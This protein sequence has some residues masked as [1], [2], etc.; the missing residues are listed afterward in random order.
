MTRQTTGANRA[1][2]WVLV[3]ASAGSCMAALDTLVVSTALTT[4]RS[5]LGATI[6]QLEWTTNAYNLSFAV[7]LLTAAALGDRFGRRRMFAS[8][9]GIFAVASAGCALAPT[10]AWLIAARAVQGIGAALIMTLA[11]ALISAAFAPERRGSALG[12]FFALTGLA[13]A[14]GPLLGGA[15]TEGIAWQWIF[16]LNVPIGIALVPLALA[17]VPESHGPDSALDLLGLVLV[18]GG[19]LG[20]V[21]GLVRGNLAGWDSAEVLATLVGGSLLVAA[22]VA[23]QR[24]A[25]QPMLPLGMFRSRAFSAANTAIFFAVGALFVGVFFLSQ[26]MQIALGS[27][28]LDAGVQLLPWTATLF[29]VAPVAGNLVDRFGERPF[30]VAGPTLQAIGMGWIAL[31]AD[32]DMAYGEM[33]APLIIAGIGVSMTFPAAQNSVVG[34]VPAAAIGKAAGVNST[35]RELGGVFGIALSVAVFAGAGSYA[36]PASFADGFV[37]AVGVAAGLSL[38]GALAGTAL[39]NRRAAEAGPPV[40][41]TPGL[42]LR[43]EQS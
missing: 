32:T 40:V 8:G 27:G 17:R 34:S 4:I 12:I 21:W 1:A 36:S 24:R 9:I 15:I 16:W 28:P 38:L 30:L 11:L 35:M 29:F 18:T 20:L 23:W 14:T 2:I 13:V 22:F 25:P 43:G 37:S 26:F 42:E 10:V 39:P 7:L 41:G 6:D 3:L 5:E 31:V 33:L 19:V